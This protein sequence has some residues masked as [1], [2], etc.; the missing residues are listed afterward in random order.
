MSVS[1][2]SVSAQL[3]SLVGEANCFADPETLATYAVD[4]KVPL[5]VVRPGSSE[6]VSG[7]VKFAAAEKL[8]M[9]ITGAR[10]KLGIGLPPRQ[11]D[12][13]LDMT[14]LNRVLA[15]DPGDLTLSVEAGIPLSDV[16]RTLAAHGQ[17]LPLEVPFMNRATA[18][19]TIASAV[20]SS[21][22]Q[23]YG[24]ARDYVLG[25][26]FITGEGIAAKSGGRVVKN[27]TGYDIHKV[28][29]GSL[30]TL[31]VITRINLRTF[32]RPANMRSFVASFETCQYA[33]ALR[34]RISQ[35]QLTLLS[36][37]I[38]S[39]G[40]A[41]VLKSQAAE[42]IERGPVAG[43][44]I[45]SK[46]WALIAS[47]AGNDQVLARSERELREMASLCGANTVAIVG[48][49]RHDILFRGLREF[50]PIAL[51]SSPAATIVKMAVL[52]SRMDDAVKL[53]S[54]AAE[55][56]AVPWA[57]MARGVGIIYFALLPAERTE[58]TLKA[59]ARATSKMFTACA[60]LDGNMTIPWCPAEWKPALNV[61]G[62]ERGD[63]QLM[64]NVKKLFDPSDVFS[65]GRF[66]GGI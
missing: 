65:P 3:A 66:A 39:P 44:S 45:S 56:N 40:A 10:T 57:A 55:E 4:G 36:F 53:A 22:R 37:E 13:A 59:V 31:G 15:Y 34:R 35:S 18:G 64:R 38:L 61:W 63:F 58:Q 62:P 8:S 1:A 41:E 28:L 2:R 12:F 19:G 33:L 20:D 14:R 9:V 25:T 21:L 7:L 5:A 23:A 43:T 29:A 54:L 30:G 51:E 16:Q 52:P 42:R 46:R 49:E 24:T 27:V 60:S 50:V 26:E 32:P 11:F 48:D 17:F 47:F 6:E